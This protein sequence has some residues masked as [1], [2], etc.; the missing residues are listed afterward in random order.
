MR[1]LWVLCLPTKFI[2]SSVFNCFTM[3]RTLALGNCAIHTYLER[4]YISYLLWNFFNHIW[5]LFLLMLNCKFEFGPSCFCYRPFCMPILLMLKR[6]RK[7]KLPF[8]RWSGVIFNS[9]RSFSEL[10]SSFIVFFI[11]YGSSFYNSF[12]RKGLMK[13]GL[14]LWNITLK[15]LQEWYVW[16]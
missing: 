7:L 6:K 4:I 13:I 8:V 5:A 10:T 16:F 11:P 3:I 12:S 9:G 2:T 15:L 1:N 14:L